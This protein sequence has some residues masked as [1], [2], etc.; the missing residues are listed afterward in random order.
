MRPL[1]SMLIVALGL[2]AAGCTAQMGMPQASLSTIEKVRS[3]DIAVMRV[4]NFVP[5]PALAGAKD[6]SMSL[7]AD[8][9]TSPVDDSFAKYLGRT[10][11]VNLKAAG[12]YDANSPLVLDGILT[13]SDVRTPFGTSSGELGAKFTL[14]KSGSTVFE[15]HI[16]VT[17]QWESSVIAA[18]AVP[19]SINHYT[20][21]FDKLTAELF[22]DKDFVTALKTK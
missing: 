3:P 6:K 8:S 20:A 2:L 21:L 1:G 17:D 14:V 12:K 19:D 11:E 22:T 9:L 10:I 18:I 5:V 15:K 4:G 13:E 7:R 16:E